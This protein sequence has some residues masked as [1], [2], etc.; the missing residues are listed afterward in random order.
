MY[1][2]SMKTSMDATLPS[3]RI[4]KIAGKLP[5]LAINKLAILREN[6]APMTM[7]LFCR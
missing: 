4:V 2:N 5:H 7:P 1:I 3:V 6:V